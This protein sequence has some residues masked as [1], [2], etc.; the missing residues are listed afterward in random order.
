[1]SEITD[2]I[3]SLV[4][5]DEK[6][7]IG[8]CSLLLFLCYISMHLKDLRNKRNEENEKPSTVEEVRRETIAILRH[9]NDNLNRNIDEIPN[10]VLKSIRSS[11][12]V[13][14]GA[15]GEL[16]GYLELKGKYDR[17]I[18]LGNIVD[19]IGIKFGDSDEEGHI[20]FIDVKTGKSARLSKDQKSLQQLIENKQINF[21]KVKVES[22]TQF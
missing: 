10:K 16:I 13:K 14:K 20:D 5:F 11:T 17:I 12:N 19:F 6:I 3:N 2:L 21:V 8:T 9:Y 4:F 22:E 1:M 18:P 7:L 15:L